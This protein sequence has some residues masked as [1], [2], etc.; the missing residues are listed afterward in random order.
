MRITLN[1]FHQSEHFSP[2]GDTTKLDGEGAGGHLSA[3]GELRLFWLVAVGVLHP[4]H[5][6]GL[7]SSRAKE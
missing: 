1:S 3:K 2:A 7:V 4:H 6:G 5:G